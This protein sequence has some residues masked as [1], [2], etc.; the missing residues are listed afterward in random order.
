M[1]HFQNTFSEKLFEFGL[2]FYMLFMVDLLHEF[3][4]GVWKQV[5]IHLICLLTALG[6]DAVATLNERY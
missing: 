1:P 6:P 2:N 3:E 4:L 5:F